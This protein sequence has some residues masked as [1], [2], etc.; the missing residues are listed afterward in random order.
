ML[1]HYLREQHGPHPGQAEDE[2]G[3]HRPI[4]YFSALRGLWEVAITRRFTQHCQRYLNVF[5]SCNE[6]GDMA[7]T[8]TLSSAWP[9]LLLLPQ[10]LGR[11]G[12]Q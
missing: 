3:G 7:V 5:I 2:D 12:G 8:V 1:Q 11:H 10:P 6:V 4:T 9:L